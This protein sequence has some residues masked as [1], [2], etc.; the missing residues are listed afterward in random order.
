MNL[1]VKN[2]DGIVYNRLDEMQEG[3]NYLG[4]YASAPAVPSVSGTFSGS[5]L[6][7]YTSGVLST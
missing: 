3:I 4:L 2:A 7:L 6:S 1:F 5:G